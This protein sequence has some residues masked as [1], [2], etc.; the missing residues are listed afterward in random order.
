[1]EH[2][3]KTIMRP[4][5]QV[6]IKQFLRLRNGCLVQENSI[7][8][9]EKNFLEVTYLPLHHFYTNTQICSKESYEKSE[10]SVH[11]ELY[12]FAHYIFSAS[13]KSR[14]KTKRKR[15]RERKERRKKMQLNEDLRKYLRSNITHGAPLEKV[16]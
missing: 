11:G 6:Q 15:T 1:M 7:P 10:Q 8:R 2:R 9:F 16:F 3:V 12:A 5:H 13:Y 4:I 14:R